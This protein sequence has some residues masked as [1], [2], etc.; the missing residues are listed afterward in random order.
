MKVIGLVSVKRKAA[1]ALMI[2]LSG[3]ELTIWRFSG[4]S[5]WGRRAFTASIITMVQ[6]KNLIYGR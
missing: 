2:R 6:D 1:R 5:D 4:C 3:L